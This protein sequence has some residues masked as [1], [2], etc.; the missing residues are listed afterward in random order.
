MKSNVGFGGAVFLTE[1]EYQ[2]YIKRMPVRYIR[3]THDLQC[4]HCGLPGTVDNPLQHAHKIGFAQG[5]LKFALTPDF[6]D[7]RTNIV[8]AHR[9]KCNKAVELSDAQAA[10]YLASLSLA[11]PEY[12]AYK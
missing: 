10:S 4:A 2:T 9:A 11:L 7:S 5:V 6:L 3:K 12:A 1:V 8:S